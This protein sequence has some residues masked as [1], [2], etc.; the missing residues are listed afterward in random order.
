MPTAPAKIIL[1]FERM[2]Y[3]HTGLYHFCLELGKALQSLADPASTA[4]YFFMTR[5]LKGIFG[6]GAQYVFQQASHKLWLPSTDQFQVWHATHQGS[7]YFPF[8][9]KIPVVLTIHD[10]NFLQGRQ[11][12]ADAQKNQLRQLQKKIDRA[13][14]V[15]AI[16]QFVLNDVKQHLQLHDIPSSVIYNGC[17]VPAFSATEKPII[18]PDS[19]FIFAIGTI[20]EKKNFHV[21]P[22]L[23]VNNDL[24]LVIAGVTHQTW[25]QQKIEEE[26]KRLGVTDRVIFAGA[27][28]ENDKYWYYQNCTAFVFPSIAEG[29]GLP[30]IEAM[31]FGKPVFLSTA[32]SLPEIGGSLA[33][34][35][36]SFEQE[37][38]RQTFQDGLAHFEGHQP[39]EAIM[40]HAQQFSWQEAASAYLNLYRQVHG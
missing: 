5:K 6:D 40:Q 10:L 39:A 34:Y 33:Y 26:A 24:K 9:R 31:Y 36:H 15:V 16:S 14:H 7:S 23:L 8:D 38:M 37:Q 30:V 27:I 29:F 32:T 13:S 3:P 12:S 2:K 1:D 4:L 21:L 25:Y 11:K 18:A 20:A 28:S 35:F 19:E 22:A 17:N